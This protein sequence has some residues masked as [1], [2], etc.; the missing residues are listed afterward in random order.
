MIIVFT[1]CVLISL[2]YGNIN[3]FFVKRKL[4]TISSSYLESCD[5]RLLTVTSPVKQ[6]TLRLRLGTCCNVSHSF[7]GFGRPLFYQLL[8]CM[9]GTIQHLTFFACFISFNIITCTSIHAAADNRTLRFLMADQCSFESVN[10]MFLPIH[11][12]LSTLVDCLC[13]SL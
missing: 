5:L 1:H 9:D 3:H 6:N 13:Q 2:G 4:K 11:S 8:F 12:R 10:H 7:P